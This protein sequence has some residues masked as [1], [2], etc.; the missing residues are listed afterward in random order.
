MQVKI[1]SKSFLKDKLKQI[2][3]FAGHYTKQKKKRFDITEKTNVLPI[4][5]RI[6]T[7][8]I[9][10]FIIYETPFKQFTRADLSTELNLWFL[11]K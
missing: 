9:N 6:I 3:D 5:V 4:C 1:P 10:F 11:L 2:T 7:T 8:Y